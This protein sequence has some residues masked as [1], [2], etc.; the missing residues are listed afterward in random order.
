M[1]GFAGY[2]DFKNAANHREELKRMTEVIIH[3]GPDSVG[4]YEDETAGL[5]FRR[6]SIIGITNG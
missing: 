4:F 5:G 1:C 2:I 6:L 3:R